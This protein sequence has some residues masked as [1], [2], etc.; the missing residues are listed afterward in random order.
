MGEL[1]L[2]DSWLELWVFN[3]SDV[4]DAKR[5]IEVALSAVDSAEWVCNECQEI[6]DASFEICWNCQH[7]NKSPK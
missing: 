4:D 7:S 3:D 1:G 6:N 2:F 5:I